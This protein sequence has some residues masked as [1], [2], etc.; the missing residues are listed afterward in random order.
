VRTPFIVLGGNC[1]QIAYRYRLIRQQVQQIFE[2]PEAACGLT[3]SPLP[4]P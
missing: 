3:S 1:D 2:H 4:N